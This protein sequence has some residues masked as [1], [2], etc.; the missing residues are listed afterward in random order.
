MSDLPLPS[1][2]SSLAMLHAAS[3]GFAILFALLASAASLVLR[4]LDKPFTIAN[5]L[6]NATLGFVTIA[7]IS[8]QVL[9]AIRRVPFDSLEGV[10]LLWWTGLI[11]C[12][13]LRVRKSR[14]R[15]RAASVQTWQTVILVAG[16]L[17]IL[18]RNYLG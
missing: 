12:A 18:G 13:A 11:V 10:Y 14:G 7:V 5:A 1:A 17:L 9:G 3:S 16:P 2:A 8:G 6:A 4:A 15:R